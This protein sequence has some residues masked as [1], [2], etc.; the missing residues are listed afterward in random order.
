MIYIS[1]K[2]TGQ[3]LNEARLKFEAAEKRIQQEGGCAVNPM[4]MI[5]VEEGKTWEQYMREAIRIMTE[6]TEIL[7]LEDWN[8]SRGAKI[9]HAIAKTLKYKIRY[10]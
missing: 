4:A 1:G 7:M 3:D 8:E 2:I 10:Q 5:E 9:E 6:C